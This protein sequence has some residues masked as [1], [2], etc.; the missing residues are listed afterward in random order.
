MFL[1]LQVALCF[2]AIANG[3]VKPSG[4]IDPSGKNVQLRSDDFANNIAVSG[5]S[6]I[7]TKDG[8]NLQLTAA[9]AALNAGFA[10]GPV[11]PVPVPT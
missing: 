5:P 6:G 9:Q 11:V 7:V 4:I 8:R 10:P 1:L 3:Q 2:L